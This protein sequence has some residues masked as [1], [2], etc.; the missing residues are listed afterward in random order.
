MVA[1]YEEIAVM[2]IQRIRKSV[3]ATRT[4][5]Q[6]L[7]KVFADVRMSR[8]REV[9]RYLTKKKKGAQ[10]KGEESVKEVKVLLSAQERFSGGLTRAVVRQLI[11]SLIDRP[12]D[13]IVIGDAGRDLLVELRPELKFDYYD[14]PDFKSPAGALLPIV[15]TLQKYEKITLYYGRFVNLVDQIP[16]MTRLFEEI[17]WHGSGTILRGG[18]HELYYLF[19][20]ELS[21]VV[22]YFNQQIF[23]MLFKQTVDESRL[24]QLGSRITAMEQA[25]NKIDEKLKRLA[26]QQRREYKKVNNDKQRQR[27]SGLA[28]W[29][30]K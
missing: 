21:E 8:Q 13:I 25:T 17:G 23:A 18:K 15:T 1:T 11:N 24:A 29:K 26:L 3:L 9:V 27:M 5:Y 10:K 12:T 6:K 30:V 19:E 20:P 16:A 14:L 28:L 7:S 22:D 2:R 4:F